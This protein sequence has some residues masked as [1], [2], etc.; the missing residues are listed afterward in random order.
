[1][2]MLMAGKKHTAS[3]ILTRKRLQVNGGGWGD[4]YSIEN[5]EYRHAA[6]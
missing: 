4:M 2:L 1:M 3:R 6:F 5:S